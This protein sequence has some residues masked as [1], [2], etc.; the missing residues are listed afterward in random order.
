VSLE[1]EEEYKLIAPD[2]CKK[3]SKKSLSKDTSK[4]RKQKSFEDSNSN[5]KFGHWGLEEN[6]RY[7]W[8]L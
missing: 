3:Y 5:R 4:P 6:K 7:H 2:L 8:F 1:S